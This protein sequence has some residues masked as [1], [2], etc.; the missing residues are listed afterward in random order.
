MENT[1]N[2][3][4]IRSGPVG[5][6]LVRLA[7]PVL[8]GLTFNLLYNIVDTWFIARI[9]P[10]DPWLVG[11]TGLVFPLFFIFLASSFGISGGVC[12]LVAR[13]IGSGKTD[14][15]DRTAES[16][17]FLA[18]A[19]SAIILGAMYP[20]ARPLLALFGGSGKVLEYGMEYL[21]WLLPTVP[22]ML[23][24]SVF[25]GILQGEG[26]TKQM[27]TSMMIGTVANCALDPVL[28]F[29]CG[30]GIAGAGLATAIGNALSFAYLVAV[31]K[32]RK[33]AVA[34]HWKARNVSA[35]VAGEILRVG[36]PQ[37]ALN[38]LASVSFIFYNRM[39]I[40]VAPV[41]LT[42]FTLYSRLEQVA[43]IPLWAM[44]SALS[45]VA[46]QAA[47]AHDVRRMREASRR[48]TVISLGVCGTLL[49]AY[50]LTSPLTFRAFQTDPTVLETALFIAPW[51]AAGTFLSVPIF[52]ITT[53]MTTAGFAGRSLAFT[54]F[55]I[56]CVSVPLCAVGAYAIGKNIGSVMA[57]ILVSSAIGLLV[58]FAVRARFFAGLASGRLS[59]RLSRETGP[60]G[61]AGSGA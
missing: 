24:A 44:S 11:S 16:G 30:M 54:A 38:Y 23:L 40:D 29:G 39:M 1:S 18:L 4:S 50:V 14:E 22:F 53:V 59:I 46:G 25:T 42:S 15:L 7:L 31:F 9:D 34:V 41:M 32:F 49:V 55:R 60:A 12:S 13:A 20:F 47:G 28:M 17:V 8:A 61:D 56:Y 36:L 45:T 52:M 2:A 57:C 10:S 21:L 48:A 5:P 37:S 27:M 43:L 3:T 19:A 26:R 33:S 35:P 6:I 51:M 58:A